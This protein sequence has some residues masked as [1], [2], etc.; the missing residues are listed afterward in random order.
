MIIKNPGVPFSHPLIQ[1][2]ISLKKE[3]TTEAALALRFIREHSIG[4]TGT[5]GKTT[6][7][8]LVHHILQAAGREALIGGNIPGQPTLSL[9]ENAPD[10]A[11]FVL[12]ISSFQIEAMDR[13]QV[14]PKYA[15]VTNIYPDHLNRYDSL[16]HY[17]QTKASLFS[18]QKP[19]DHAFWNGDTQWEEL[20]TEHIQDGVQLHNLAE[21]RRSHHFTFTTPLTGTHNQENI[22][23]AAEVARTL[24][25]EERVISESI[26]TFTGV[27]HRLQR[28]GPIRGIT[29]IND[30][31]STT[32][33]ALEKALAAQ[34]EPFVLIAGG[35]TKHLPFSE[36]LLQNLRRLPHIIW[37]PG[38]GTQEIIDALSHT[39]VAKQ[40]VVASLAEAVRV[41]TEIA[42]EEN[43]STV[44]FSPGFT[45]FEMF[46]NEFHRGD[47][48]LQEVEILA[49]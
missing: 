8:H 15:V 36:T 45:S 35:T 21:E 6:T 3:V 24:G 38:S 34:T 32:P 4:I 46:D 11:V 7:T 5:R 31:A 10:S 39:K 9:L 47:V 29:Y 42:K 28:V 20:I 14:S 41:A 17:A 43:L 44:L 40:H 2:A 18:W 26:A 25:V 33:I 30:T 13:E 1:E 12:E 16:E 19:G 27:K 23:V 22:L 37:L 48:F 49:T